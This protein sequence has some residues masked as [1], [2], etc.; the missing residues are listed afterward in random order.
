MLDRDKICWWLRNINRY[1]YAIEKYTAIYLTIRTVTT[2]KT[3]YIVLDDT[4]RAWLSWHNVHCLLEGHCQTHNTELKLRILHKRVTSIYFTSKAEC[5]ITMIQCI[6]VRYTVVQLVEALRYK[7][8]VGGF[9]SRCCPW[10]NPSGR[11]MALGLTQP[12]TDVPITNIS[13]GVKA[14]G[15]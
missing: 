15:A 8:E 10:H 4:S 9:D 7:S 1:S 5:D 2:D 3:W 12:L 11:P 14:A 6:L 13:W